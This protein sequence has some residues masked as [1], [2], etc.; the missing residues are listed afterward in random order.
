VNYWLRKGPDLL[1]HIDET[2][3][4]S[5]AIA[6]WYLGLEGY[7]L[8]VNQ[9][10]L[11]VDPYLRA[12]GD[13][14]GASQRQYEPPFHGGD[15]HHADWVLC[16]HH[17]RDHLDPETLGPLSAASPAA[18]FLI[19]AP[20]VQL[21]I[22]IGIAATR[23][24]PARAG[25][26]VDI[27]GFRVT[28]IPAAHV[29]LETDARG[30]HRYLGYVIDTGIVTVYHAG[31]TV[32]FPELPALLRP[33]RIDIALLPINGNDRHRNEHNI[34]GNLDF[35]EAV[36]LAVDIGAKMVIPMHYDLLPGNQTNPAYFVDYLYHN[37]PSQPY[38]MLALGECLVQ[39]R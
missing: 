5:N 2:V 22:D 30:D 33:H 10:I 26:T 19:P 35:R 8:K 1:R 13:Q 17:H 15:V 7:V 34:V 32:D 21:C 14:P 39:H 16:T 25:Q 36:D 12:A 27:A 9:T 23:I 38:R 31:D 20:S 3:V 29:A 11:Y 18:R 28:S 37:Y 4:P 6:L 24:T